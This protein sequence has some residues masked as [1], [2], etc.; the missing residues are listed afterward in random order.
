MRE[1]IEQR[2]GTAGLADTL[3]MAT[4]SQ[5][6]AT[7][8]VLACAA[9]APTMAADLSIPAGWIGYQVSLIYLSGTF[10]SAVAGGLVHRHGAALMNAVTLLCAG[11][12][13]LALTSGRP[14]PMALASLLI[15]VGYGFNNPCSS[16]M[17]HRVTPDRLRN[18]VFSVK[19]AGVPV[20]G[21]ATALMLPPLAAV[22]GWRAALTMAAVPM[23]LLAAAFAL[24]RARWDDDRVPGAPILRAILRGQR[25]VMS[26]PDL[27]A[28]SLL[29]LLYSAIQLSLSA[30]TVTMLVH[31][32][33]WSPVRAGTAAAGVQVSGAVGRI[34]WGVV[35]D[36]VRAG[37]LVLTALGLATALCCAA[38]L[39][40]GRLPP[41][42]VVAV[43]CA[44]GACSIGWNGVLLA[45]TARL[46]PPGAGTLTGEVLVYVFIGVVIG[47]SSFAALYSYLGTCSE[48]FGAF[49]ALALGGAALATLGHRAQRAAGRS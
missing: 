6:M 16:H 24:A 9:I 38:L 23:L 20:G 10:A 4:A 43:L 13:T 30:F 34:V 8:A 42:A 41:L 36:I 17:L 39:L 44:M 37:F 49:G 19:Q 31:D 21:I 18:L 28:L 29:G 40:G 47:P 5:I 46:S 14:V 15:G 26:R 45:E 11:A 22:S 27:R 33:G 32:F 48:T 2:R 35:A 25:M 7:A 3:A 1:L 12:G